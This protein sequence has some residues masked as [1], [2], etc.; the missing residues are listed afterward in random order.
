MSETV[1]KNPSAIVDIGS[2]DE[3]EM[4]VIDGTCGTLTIGKDAVLYLSWTSF[5][6]SSSDIPAGATIVGVEVQFARYLQASGLSDSGIYLRK[7]DSN[8]G[9]N[10]ASADLWETTLTT[11][12]YGGSTDLWGATI[13]RDDILNSTFGFQVTT[14]QATAEYTAYVDGV[15]MKVYYTAS[16]GGGIVA[17]MHYYRHL[18]AGGVGRQC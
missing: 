16:G 18:M 8:I 5:G 15:K 9:N 4:K 7:N 2:V 11:K 13:T 3:T 6:F 17:F 12:T 10:K 1:W 14:T